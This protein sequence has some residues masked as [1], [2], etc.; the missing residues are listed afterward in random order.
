MNEIVKIYNNQQVR[1]IQQDG[2]PWFVAKDVCDVL[3][4]RNSRD[5]IS[6][7]MSDE[8]G[9]GTT[10]T[11][12]GKQ[13]V[14][15]VNEPGVYR[16]VFR[17]RKREAEKFKRWVFHEV[18]PSIRRTGAYVAPN[19]GIEQLAALAKKIGEMAKRLIAQNAEL[20][21]KLAYLEQF[22]P[23]GEFGE[24][25]AVNGCPKWQQRRGCYVSRNGRRPRRL[26][27]DTDGYLQHD[28]FL[29]FLPAVLIGEAVNIINIHCP[30][31]LEDTANA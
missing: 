5:A 30:K 6:T 23:K 2:E 8:K 27:P 7:L 14:V 10:D 16:L 9:V 21:E 1:I 17:S 26:N 18:L 3:G 25:S 31:L 28:L 20:R 15:L 11:L 13:E 4:I 29:D 19:L 12:G 24:P 22:V